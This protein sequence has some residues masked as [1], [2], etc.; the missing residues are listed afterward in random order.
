MSGVGS[1]HISHTTIQSHFD[2]SQYQGDNGQHTL[3]KVVSGIQLKTAF[4]PK[5]IKPRQVLNVV[6]SS[7]SS[8]HRPWHGPMHQSDKTQLHSPVV[9]Y[10]SVPPVSLHKSL[11]WLNPPGGR[12]QKEE[13]IKSCNLRKEDPSCL[14]LPHYHWSF[15]LLDYL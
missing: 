1:G 3:R 12:Q 15:Q 9:R 4:V 7:W 14:S 5:T 13:E 2:N 6:L 8:L 10:Q 11:D